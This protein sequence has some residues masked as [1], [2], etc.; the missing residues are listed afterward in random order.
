VRD[1][2]AFPRTLTRIA[3]GRLRSTRALLAAFDGDRR[4]FVVAQRNADDDDPG[5][6]ALYDVGCIARIASVAEEGDAVEVELEV[7]ARARAESFRG[8]SS[9]G[10]PLVAQ[11]REAPMPAGACDP[12]VHARLEAI[13]ERVLRRI[14]LPFRRARKLLVGAT[15]AELADVILAHLRVSPADQ[16]RFL[17]SDDVAAKVEAVLDPKVIPWVDG[18]DHERDLGL[19]ARFRRWLRRV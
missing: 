14:D 18:P 19:Y 10:E 4:L 7:I 3:V 2:V 5:P 1:A 15:P 9:P 12:G 17:E 8:A 11:T 16:Q 13:A 6:E